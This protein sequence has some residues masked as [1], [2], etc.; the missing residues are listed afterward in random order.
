MV[1]FL[2]R[3][4]LCVVFIGV[5]IISL[6]VGAATSARAVEPDERLADPVLEARARAISAE[7]RCL[8]CQNQ[9]IDD[10]SAPL[11]RDLRLLV[12]EQLVA[13]NSD[14]DVTRFLVD[15]YGEFVLLRPRFSS[16][17]LVLWLAPPLLLAFAVLA[18]WRRSRH[19]ID[20]FALSDSTSALT[21]DEARR[22]D[23]ILS[24]LRERN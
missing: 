20:T 16:Q 6:N 10:S 15:R 23:K 17:T 22:L 11:A 19:R 14:A 7:L 21:T 12:R 13:G 18:L 4:K 5:L 24:G 2:Y 8:V 9:S 3:I 1:S